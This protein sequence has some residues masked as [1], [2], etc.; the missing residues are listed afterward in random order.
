V[1]EYAFNE[2][3]LH[4]IEANIIPRNAGSI[5]AVEKAGFTCEGTSKKYLQINGV[6]EDHA[7]Y[8]RLNEKVE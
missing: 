3:K 1:V 8:V 7:H 2:L 6:W 4:R 5:R